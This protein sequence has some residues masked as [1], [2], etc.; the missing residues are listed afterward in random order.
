[1]FKSDP[2]S[3]IIPFK[4][5]SSKDCLK[6]ISREFKILLDSD[7]T[8]LSKEVKTVGISFEFKEAQYSLARPRIIDDEMYQ[9]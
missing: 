6:V 3:L 9:F 4:N 7:Y 5:I 8:T 1:M 2:S